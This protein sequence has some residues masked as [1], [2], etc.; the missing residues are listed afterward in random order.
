[1]LTGELQWRVQYGT[2]GED[3][4]GSVRLSHGQLY[5]LGVGHAGGDVPGNVLTGATNMALVKLRLKDGTLVCFK[6]WAATRKRVW[7]QL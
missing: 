2:A 4:L 3:V 1:M 5:V 6:T 7:A